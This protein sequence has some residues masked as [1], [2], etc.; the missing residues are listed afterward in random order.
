M[1]YNENENVSAHNRGKLVT[2]LLCADLYEYIMYAM[3]SLCSSLLLSDESMHLPR[4]VL[5]QV[6]CRLH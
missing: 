5:Q 6:D 1:Y 3:V 4:Y 2:Y